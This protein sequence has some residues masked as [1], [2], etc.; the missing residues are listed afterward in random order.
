MRPGLQH[1]GGKGRAVVHGKDKDAH[2]GR[3]RAQAGDAVQP[4][5]AGQPKVQNGEIRLPVAGDGDALFAEEAAST[6]P[7]PTSVR[8]WRQPRWIIG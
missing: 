2:R 8:S 1:A 3:H 6:S 7:N 5:G 4:T